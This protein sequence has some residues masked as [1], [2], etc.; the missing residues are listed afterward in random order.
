[1]SPVR[2]LQNGNLWLLI[3]AFAVPGTLFLLVASTFGDLPKSTP[4]LGFALGATVAVIFHRRNVVQVDDG[5]ITLIM[6][7]KSLSVPWSD[8]ERIEGHRLSARIR[9]RSN[10]RGVTFAMFDPH[11]ADSPVAQ[12][13]HAH[14]NA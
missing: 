9:R 14:L 12:A 8:V 2:A 4:I 5:G 7:G 11:W 10:Q 1:M 3:V 13:I 6:G